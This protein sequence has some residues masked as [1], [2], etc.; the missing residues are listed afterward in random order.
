MS[1]SESGSSVHRVQ[2]RVERM[3]V[4]FGIAGTGFVCCRWGLLPAAGFAAG[5]ALSWLNYR[6]LKQGVMTIVPPA[7]SAPDGAQSG[8]ASGGENAPA[9]VEAPAVARKLPLKAFAKFFGRYVLLIVALYVILSRS[10]L[11]AAPF[12]AGLFVV[13]AAVVAEILYELMGHSG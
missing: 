12:L 3:I 2:K 8:E 7:A 9:A 5:A 11:P 4:V 13:V 10:V 1:A 6:W